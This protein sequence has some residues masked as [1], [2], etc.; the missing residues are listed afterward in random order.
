[1][2]VFKTKVLHFKIED[3][4]IKDTNGKRKFKRMLSFLFVNKRILLAKKLSLEEFDLVFFTTDRSAWH[5]LNEPRQRGF[6]RNLRYILYSMVKESTFLNGNF[7]VYKGFMDV[8][9][10][11]TSA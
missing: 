6:G 2:V 3:T 1:M 4:S 8:L 10:I 11:L 7:C 9:Y 5:V